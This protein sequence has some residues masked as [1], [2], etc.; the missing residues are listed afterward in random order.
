MNNDGVSYCNRILC[1]AA[2]S[3][4]LCRSELKA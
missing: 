2:L 3:M 4:I 1:V